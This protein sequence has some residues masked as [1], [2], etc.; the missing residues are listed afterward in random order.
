MSASSAAPQ[1]KPG[2]DAQMKFRYGLW[3]AVAAFLLALPVGAAQTCKPQNI[4]ASTATSDFVLHRDGTA[5]HKRTGLTWMRCAL[6]QKWDDKT[7]A[8]A[9]AA[10]E[11]QQALQAAAAFNAAGGYAGHADWRLPNIKELDS[12]VEIQCYFP[13]INLEVFPE[14]PVKRFW[15][16]SF[17]TR[18][19]KSF[20]LF[21]DF[22]DGYGDDG[23]AMFAYPV[24]LVRGGQPFGS[25]DRMSPGGR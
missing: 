21:V 7:C 13:A 15:S 18:H 8:G 3:A 10:Y 24:R 19:P 12:I 11:W 4:P 9:A 14:T 16:D 25:F 6:G 17:D 5:S 2:I 23:R 20:A 1:Q 22:S